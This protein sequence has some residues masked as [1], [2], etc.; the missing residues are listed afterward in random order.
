LQKKDSYCIE[1]A[2]EGFYI[3]FYRIFAGFLLVSCVFLD[4]FGNFLGFCGIFCSDFV[5][6]DC[7]IP[8]DFRKV[9]AR[10]PKDSIRYHNYIVIIPKI[11][12]G[13]LDFFLLQISL[14]TSNF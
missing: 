12:N 2:V 8:L 6:D 11:R 1:I 5:V 14:K 7:Y 4:F 3:C 9:T 13:N 10:F